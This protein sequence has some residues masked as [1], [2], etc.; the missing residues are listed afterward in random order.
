MNT[1]PEIV[2]F[3]TIMLSAGL[4]IGFFALR[5]K[6]K[7][8]KDLFKAAVDEKPDKDVEIERIRA[9]DRAEARDL[10]ERVVREKLDVIKTALAMG[11]NQAE[12]QHL[13]QRLEQLIGS[14]KLQ[15]LLQG[16][17][18]PVPSVELLDAD[19]NQEL[20]AVKRTELQRETQ[21][22]D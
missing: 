4:G 15:T 12:L 6:R 22:R 18:A 20:A 14:E 1:I 10:Y 11:Y 21:H 3:I 16:Q 2:M 5:F 9:K 17:A 7:F 13:D 19:L 8:Y